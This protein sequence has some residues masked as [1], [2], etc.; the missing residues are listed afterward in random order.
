[1]RTAALSIFALSAMASA[2]TATLRVI[3]NTPHPVTWCPWNCNSLLPTSWAVLSL[4]LTP[5]TGWWSRCPT[6]A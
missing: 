6:T 1:M 4:W 5:A 3:S 2:G